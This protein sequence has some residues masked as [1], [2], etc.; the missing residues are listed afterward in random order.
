MPL[1]VDRA[2]LV[3]RSGSQFLRRRSH[4]PARS[5]SLGRRLCR[6]GSPPPRP[7][8]NCS[9]RRPRSETDAGRRSRCRRASQSA[10]PEAATA[11]SPTPGARSFSYAP[12][13]PPRGATGTRISSRSSAGL[14]GRS[15]TGPGVEL[16][17]TGTVRVSARP[18]LDHARS[19]R[20]AANAAD[21][22]LRT[23]RPWPQRS[24]EFVPRLRTIGSAITRSASMKI[25][26]VLGHQRRL[27][28][29][30]R[31]GVIAPIRQLVAPPTGTYA[32]LVEIIDVDQSP[33]GRAQPEASSSGGRLW[34]PATTRASL[35]PTGR[36]GAIACLD[37]RRL[38]VLEM[39]RYLASRL[40]ARA[41]QGGVIRT[42]GGGNMVNHQTSSRRRRQWGANGP[43]T[44][45]FSPG[46][47]RFAR[48]AGPSGGRAVRMLQA[49]TLSPKL[50]AFRAG[51]TSW[52]RSE[53][54]PTCWGVKRTRC[55]EGH[56]VAS[57][58]IFG[59][60]A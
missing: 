56:R 29:F 19:P 33:S 11:Q 53:P 44:D 1:V 57:G 14:D 4:R 5:F 37:A 54:R 39:C 58:N 15:R 9:A 16:G 51:G 59:R 50:G 27:E 12:W 24:A 31:A 3:G 26:L 13:P 8:G 34:P 7:R 2:T 30:A 52:A 48:R 28:Q 20:P 43:L 36:A 10:T 55:V 17:A 23:D 38:L 6:A 32:S 42:H 18:A 60:P 25:G 21:R 41:F 35:L 45:R 49:V 22:S 40:H 46:T 47:P